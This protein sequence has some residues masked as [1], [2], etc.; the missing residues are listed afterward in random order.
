MQ[1]ITH[2]AQRTTHAPWIAPPGSIRTTETRN[3]QPRVPQNNPALYANKIAANQ[4][5]RHIPTTPCISERAW[6]AGCT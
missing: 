3:N 6:G 1:S 4:M 5:L 2:A